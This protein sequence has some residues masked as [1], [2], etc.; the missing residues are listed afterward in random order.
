M[1]ININVSVCGVF[2]LGMFNVSRLGNVSQTIGL[3]YISAEYYWDVKL[4]VDNIYFQIYQEP[5]CCIC[6]QQGSYEK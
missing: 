2:V 1:Y 3:L 5:W 4:P 6:Y